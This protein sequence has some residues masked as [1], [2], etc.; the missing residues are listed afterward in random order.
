VISFDLQEIEEK[1]I[2]HDVCMPGRSQSSV[3][4]NNQKK[5]R[6]KYI[7]WSSI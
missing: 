6:R 5:T 7:V 4:E 3:D 2:L 1:M